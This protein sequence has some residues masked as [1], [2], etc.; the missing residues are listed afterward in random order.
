[1]IIH[2]L[3]WPVMQRRFRN[4]GTPAWFHRRVH[5][6][7]RASI[8]QQP[9][10]KETY[11]GVLVALMFI[12]L[13]IAQHIWGFAPQHNVLWFMFPGLWTLG[14]LLPEVVEAQI[15]VRDGRRMYREVVARTAAELTGHERLA[16]AQA[17]PS[18]FKIGT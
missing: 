17:H 5:A 7:I 15:L 13:P 2:H 3:M 4:P 11:L 12:G 16:Y 6:Q 8:R 9:S 1:M 10:S 14:L 18:G